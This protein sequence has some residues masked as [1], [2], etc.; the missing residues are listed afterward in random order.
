MSDKV[1]DYSK[2]P[3]SEHKVFTLMGREGR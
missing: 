2:V 3:S 1:G